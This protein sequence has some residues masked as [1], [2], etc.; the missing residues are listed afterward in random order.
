MMNLKVPEGNFQIKCFNT[1]HNLYKPINK[2]KAHLYCSKCKKDKRYL[3][4]A[5]EDQKVTFKKDI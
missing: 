3:L 2:Y 1:F 4:L 5:L